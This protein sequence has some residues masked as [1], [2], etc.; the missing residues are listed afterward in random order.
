MIYYSDLFPEWS[1]CNSQSHT[2]SLI[3]SIHHWQRFHTNTC[4]YKGDIMGNGACLGLAW[5]AI[6]ISL[7]KHNISKL[8]RMPI[9]PFLDICILQ[10]IH[11]QI[12][13]TIFHK[14]LI[15][16]GQTVVRQIYAI[17]KKCLIL[18]FS[19]VFCWLLT[20]GFSK[21]VEQFHCKTSNEMK[22]CFHS[23]CAVD[24][25]VLDLTSQ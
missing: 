19:L 21:W 4:P 10:Y 23:F 22:E 1:A 5:M 11:F 13:R 7:I 15:E 8:V 24:T 17:I 20:R 6:C 3:W 25:I 9:P 18:G 16:T 14:P 12:V 2:P